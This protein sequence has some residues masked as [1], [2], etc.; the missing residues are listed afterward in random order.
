MK[1]LFTRTLLMLLVAFVITNVQAQGTQDGDFVV[2]LKS[3]GIGAADYVNTTNTETCGWGYAQFGSAVTE[4]F[5]GEMVW[6]HDLVGGDSLGCDSTAAESLDGKIVLVRRGVCEFGAKALWAEKAGAKAVI[7]INH[8]NTATQTGCT[9][10]GLG[11]G[12]VGAQVTVPVIFFPRS[13]GELIDADFAAGNKPRACFLLPRMYDAAAAYH[14]ATPVTQVDTLANM[15]V[16][17]VNRS[18]SV[19]TGLVVKADVIAPDGSV[20]SIPVNIA[21][22]DPGVDT[23]IV[24]PGYLPPTLV[25]TFK[26]LYSNNKYTEGRDTLTRTFIQTA[27]TWATDNFVIDPQGIGPTNAQFQMNS[28]KHQVGGLCLTGDDPAGAKATFASFGI[29]NKDSVYVDGGDP[30][31]NDI[32]VIVYDGDI[33]NDG[34]IDV[35]GTFEEM[36]D[37]FQQVGF[38]TYTMGANEVNDSIV[39]VPVGDLL[40]NS[41]VEMKPNHPYYISLKYDGLLAG[42]GRC[43]RFSNTIGEF[44]LNFPTTPV[45]V[46]QMYSGWSGATVIQRLHTEGFNP[47]VSGTQSPRLDASKVTLSPNPAID[48]VNIDFDLASLNKAVVVRLLDVTGNVVATEIRREFQ[49]GRISLNTSTLPSGAYVAWVT[50]NEGTTFKKVMICH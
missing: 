16:H 45:Y 4:E 48:M 20:A 50:S 33:D 41:F 26:I 36:D 15:Q 29:A 12:A 1:I 42:H 47:I 25:G 32:L 37:N 9:T 46:D 28:F 49:N 44:Y 8:Y 22:L 14:Y 18:S 5:E 35:P 3:P 43:V 38:G 13:V 10:I 24:F 17:F 19:Q 39:S 31:S 23:T 30:G 34:V 27:H 6:I 21:S 2:R 40:G 11:A 7:I